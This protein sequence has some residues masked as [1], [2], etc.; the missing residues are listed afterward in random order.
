MVKSPGAQAVPICSGSAAHLNPF[1]YRSPSCA[2]IGQVRAPY[3]EAAPPMAAGLCYP[4][5]FWRGEH[6][7]ALLSGPLPPCWG[8]ED[9][10][11][12]QRVKFHSLPM[13]GPLRPLPSCDRLTAVALPESRCSCRENQQRVL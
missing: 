11:R 4:R 7:D 9:W 5:V 3:P 10:G 8:Q 6:R 12:S 1:E 13:T 2:L